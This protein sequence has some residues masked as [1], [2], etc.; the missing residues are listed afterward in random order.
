M[1]TSKVRGISVGWSCQAHHK[2]SVKDAGVGDR[3]SAEECLVFFR[4]VVVKRQFQKVQS[5]DRSS[6]HCSET[7]ERNISRQ[8]RKHANM[9][10][11]E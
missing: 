1:S 3:V 5:S 4:V 7:I 9:K 10:S 6:F 8:C 11:G 2:G